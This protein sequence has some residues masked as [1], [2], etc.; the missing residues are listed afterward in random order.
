MESVLESI[1]AATVYSKKAEGSEYDPVCN[2][3]GFAVDIDADGTDE[4][5]LEQAVKAFYSAFYRYEF[6]DNGSST[7]YAKVVTDEGPEE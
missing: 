5:N 4:E 7:T 2:M 1:W 6:G 3:D